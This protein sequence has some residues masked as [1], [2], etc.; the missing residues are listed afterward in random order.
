MEAFKPLLWTSYCFEMCYSLRFGGYLEKKRFMCYN[1]T[2]DTIG[3][4]MVAP[5]CSRGV[6]RTSERVHAFVY[7]VSCLSNL[8][9]FVL[10]IIF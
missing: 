7:N 10:E 2:I 3:Q 5:V 1:K 8:F 4:L 9:C 6:S